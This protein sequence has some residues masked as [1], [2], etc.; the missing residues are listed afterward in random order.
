MNRPGDV[1]SLSKIITK[2]AMSL[3][4]LSYS[5]GKLEQL[6]CALHLDIGSLSA[7]KGSRLKRRIADLT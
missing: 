3:S 7:C 2:E 1:L 6:G 5:F 4:T